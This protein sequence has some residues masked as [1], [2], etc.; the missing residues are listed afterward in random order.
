MENLLAEQDAFS[1]RLY[2]VV[3]AFQNIIRVPKQK[4]DKAADML[5]NVR[6]LYKQARSRVLSISAIEVSELCERWPS[7][8]KK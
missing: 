6:C 7:S 5:T 2:E 3:A 4:K 1:A 8:L